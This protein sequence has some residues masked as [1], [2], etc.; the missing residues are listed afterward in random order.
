[1]I[2]LLPLLTFSL[3]AFKSVVAQTALWSA[4]ASVTIST[5]YEQSIGQRVYPLLR[6]PPS[7]LVGPAVEYTYFGNHMGAKILEA[8]LKGRLP[9][10]KD[11]G[12]QQP[13]SR[14][15]LDKLLTSTDTIVVFNADTYEETVQIVQNEPNPDDFH[16]INLHLQLS[17][18]A[19]GSIRQTI[20]CA[21]FQINPF[22]DLGNYNA[23]G[24]HLYFAVEVAN[25]QLKFRRSSWNMID[26]HKIQL[27]FSEMA[28]APAAQFTTLQMVENLMEQAKNGADD[29][30]VS[31]DGEYQVLSSE[32]REQLA[33]YV[34]TVETYSPEDYSQ[35]TEYVYNEFEPTSL[36]QIRLLHYWAWDERKAE[37]TILPL[38]Y[39]LMLEERNE[40]GELLFCRPLFYH[41]DARYRE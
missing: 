6:R 11:E 5:D 40:N 29:N 26:Q 38:G 18:R 7:E 21:S 3:F 12:L 8:A 20:Q 13:F 28:I 34:D 22:D 32:E 36:N 10:Y 33:G 23:N 25:R 16:Q 41:I 37:L 15:E 14:L 2:R 4:N 27:P 1:M 35:I 19:D 24:R 31:A 9:L 39:A 30:F 17:Y